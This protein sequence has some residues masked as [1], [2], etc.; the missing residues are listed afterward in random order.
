MVSGTPLGRLA[1][2]DDVAGLVAYLCSPEA[3]FLT[4]QLIMIDGGASA[5][6][7]GWSLFRDLW[8]TPTSAGDDAI[9]RAEPGSQP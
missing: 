7:G 8:T 9:K 5:E 1:T 4:G 3:S 6:G 2:V